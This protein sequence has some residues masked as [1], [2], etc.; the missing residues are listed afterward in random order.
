MKLLTLDAVR[1]ILRD[2]D[3]SRQFPDLKIQILTS[4][5]NEA[6]SDHERRQQE[7]SEPT[8]QQLRRQVDALH[9]A[10]K[11]VKLALPDP[12]QRSLLNYLSAIGEHYAEKHG[13]HPNL[14]PLTA[15]GILPEE[16][17][18]TEVSAVYYYRSSERVNEILGG[19]SQL[20]DWLDYA[21]A[22]PLT[23]HQNWV[24]ANPPEEIEDTLGPTIH[25]PPDAHRESNTVAL[26]GEELPRLYEQTFSEDYG[27]GD[28]GPGIR[29]VS[30]VLAA[31]DL[32]FSN[33][34]IPKYRTRATN[35]RKA[36]L[37]ATPPD[38]DTPV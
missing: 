7:T 14:Q 38:V 37:P 3:P 29:F 16:L 23:A 34:T 30:G 36:T 17:G 21:T 4:K 2:T 35:R 28:T 19:V 22:K 31:A 6:L 26:I 8:A 13:P 5:L 20:L 32:S 33:S 15:G 12:Q 27:N 25:R 1:Q 11:R 18:G 10:L 9:T 24:D